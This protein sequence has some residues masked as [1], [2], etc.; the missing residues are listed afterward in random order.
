MFGTQQASHPNQRI[1]IMPCNSDYMTATGY[2]TEISR[3][4]CLLDE[5]D[6][7]KFTPSC[8]GGYHPLVYGKIT[9]K[10]GDAMVSALCASLQTIDV[11]E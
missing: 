7:K 3:V 5:L 11:T 10:L 4:A 9:R 6:G 8:W 1:I 2:E